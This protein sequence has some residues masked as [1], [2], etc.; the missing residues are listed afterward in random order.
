MSLFAEVRLDHDALPLVPTIEAVPEATLTVRYAV[1]DPDGEAYLFF[2][3]TTD[4]PDEVDEALAGDPTVADPRVVADRSDG[5]LYRVRVTADASDAAETA[6]LDVYVRD[7]T[8][9]GGAWRAELDVP[10]RETLVALRERCA[11][12]GIAFEL[13]RLHEAD[14]VADDG[15][16][17]L[18]DA[19]REILLLAYRR[20]YFEEPRDASLQDLGNALGVSATAAGARLRRATARLIEATI[21]GARKA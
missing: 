19:Q 13:V 17:V 4:R 10:D 9:D 14:G 3:A 21:E 15:G 7:L 16:P 18:T 2:R 20:G 11:S 1:P 12:E 8:S 5:R 6:P